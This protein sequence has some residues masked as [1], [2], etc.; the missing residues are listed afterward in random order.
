MSASAS[1]S[2]SEDMYVLKRNGDREIVAFDK[3]LA[4]LKTLGAQAKITA[5]NYTTLVIKIIDQLYDG[6]PTT[7]LYLL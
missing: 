3:I 2:T 7:K 1:A 5:V 6:I 4:R